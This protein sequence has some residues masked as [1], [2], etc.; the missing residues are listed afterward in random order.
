[1][2]ITCG[3]CG[4]PLTQSEYGANHWYCTRCNVSVKID[5]VEG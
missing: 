5:V 1:M 2:L 4:K 3:I